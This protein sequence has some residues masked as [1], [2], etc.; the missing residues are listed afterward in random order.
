MINCSGGNAALIVLG[1]SAFFTGKDGLH[2][3]PK[4]P[5]I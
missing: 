5:K 1:L 4:E 2:G 3:I